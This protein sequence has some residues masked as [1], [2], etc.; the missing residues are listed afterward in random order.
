MRP[1][2]FSLVLLLFVAACG[3]AVGN[4]ILGGDSGNG[5]L[6]DATQAVD[7][8]H[9]PN[10]TGCP[11]N[12]GD[13]VSCYTGP[14]GTLNVGACRAG[15]QTCSVQGESSAAFGACTGEILPSSTNTCRG[16]DGG[17]RDG[18]PSDSGT[19]GHDTST[20]TDAASFCPIACNPATSFC[21]LSYGPP[22]LDAGP[23]PFCLPFDSPCDASAPSCACAN[24]CAFGSCNDNQGEVTVICPF[25]P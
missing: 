16:P 1:S 10:Y 12:V 20:G 17:A 11:C 19:G 4:V 5:I 7:C 13:V 2:C 23:E 3:D 14:S 25:H 22:E 8:A 24:V 15:T 9:G 21:E 18:G 6:L